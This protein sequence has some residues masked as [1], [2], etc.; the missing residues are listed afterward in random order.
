MSATKDL[1][2]LDL[3]TLNAVVNLARGVA[4]TEWPPP[5]DGKFLFRKMKD[6]IDQGELP[7]PV[8]FAERPASM[9]TKVRLLDLWRW[10]K[11]KEELWDPV[12]RFCVEWAAARD[13]DLDAIPQSV[14]E[15][16]DKRQG[17]KEPSL[18]DATIREMIESGMRP[19]ETVRWGSFCRLVR[20]RCGVSEKEPPRGYSDRNIRRVADAKRKDALA[21]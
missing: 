7:V 17:G 20:E 3:L 2:R 12:R 5:P 6:A 18:R 14:D 9:Y 10:V 4:V 15:V 1:L 11:D 8:A 21:K 13:V 16:P 19:G